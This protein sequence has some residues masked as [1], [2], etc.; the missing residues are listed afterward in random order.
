MINKKSFN[1]VVLVGHVGSAP[2][3]RYTKEGSAVS[4]FSLATH[5]LKKTTS[6]EEKE[7]I[8]S[9]TFDVWADILPAILKREKVL[10]TDYEIAAGK[11]KIS[12]RKNGEDTTTLIFK[13]PKR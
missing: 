7:M 2:E 8:Y 5:E 1:R 9:K 13:N 12:I 6:E 11:G 4:T 3:T 10:G